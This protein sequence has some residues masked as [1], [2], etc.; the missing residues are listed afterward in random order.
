MNMFVY[1]ISL[2]PYKLHGTVDASEIL[3][4]LRLVVDL[5]VYRV[6][7]IPSGASGMAL[8]A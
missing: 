1:I 7:Y 5:I 3:H 4:Q 6:L 2:R 8:K